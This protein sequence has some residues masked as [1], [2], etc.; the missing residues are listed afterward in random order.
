M[1][2]LV[3]HQNV[4]PPHFTTKLH[5]CVYEL[6]F[7]TCEHNNSGTANALTLSMPVYIMRFPKS[8]CLHMSLQVHSSSAE[9]ARELFKPSKDLTSLRVCYNQIFCEWHHKWSRFKPFFPT[10]SGPGPKPLDQWFPICL[11]LR[12]PA[13]DNYIL[14]HPVANSYNSAS[15][16]V[17]SLKMYF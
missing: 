6:M 17:D 14:R 16:F 1:T 8:I 13:E 5:P 7:T 4:P 9:C 2:I 12:H 15:R 3:L 11:G 10:S